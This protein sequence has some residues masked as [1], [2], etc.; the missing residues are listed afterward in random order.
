MNICEEKLNHF[1]DLMSEELVIEN[2]DESPDEFLLNLWHSDKECFSY[3]I[4]GSLRHM[5]SFRGMDDCIISVCLSLGKETKEL[6][7]NIAL[8]RRKGSRWSSGFLAAAILLGSR[9]VI[10]KFKEDFESAITC[11]VRSDDYDRVK[12]LNYIETIIFLKLISLKEL[13]LRVASMKN[14]QF[15]RFNKPPLGGL[16]ARL[17]PQ[18]RQRNLNYMDHEEIKLAEAANVYFTKGAIGLKEYLDEKGDSE[19]REREYLFCLACGR[20]PEDYGYF[21]HQ[22]SLYKEPRSKNICIEAMLYVDN[23]KALGFLDEEI[24]RYD[25]NR[26]VKKR[27]YDLGIIIIRAH[28]LLFYFLLQACYYLNEIND[29]LVNKLKILAEA[30]EAATSTPAMLILEKF[31][32]LPVDKNRIDSTQELLFK[33]MPSAAHLLSM[34]KSS[35]RL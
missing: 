34:A 23:N 27:G 15:H 14:E 20:N 25:L 1:L 18:R 30:R 19:Y 8:R 24:G 9:K 13:I 26:L 7:E 4:N 28:K 31:G 22:Y 21:K 33:T 2:R 35:G 32:I 29:S 17:M 12:V 10:D 3:V 6:I 5:K 11:G 16:P